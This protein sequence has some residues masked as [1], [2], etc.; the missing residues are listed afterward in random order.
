MG[1]F[2]LF[3]GLLAALYGFIRNY[4][5]AIIALTLISRIAMYPLTRKQM[6]S[7]RKMQALQPEVTR[8]RTK[9]KNNKQKMNEEM[10]ALYKESGVNPLG[11]CLPLLLQMPIFIALF[12]VL[13]APLKYMGYHLVGSTTTGH[14]VV[15]EGVSGIMRTLQQSS[16]AQGLL[17]VPDK[18][19]TFLGFLRLDC[20]ARATMPS[21]DAVQLPGN[22]SPC[23]QSWLHAVPYIVLLIAM[24]AT[25]YVQQKQMQ[26]SQDPNNPQAQQAKMMARIFPIMFLF[27]GFTFP[28]GLVIYWTTSNLWGIVQQRL[29]LRSA[30]P[31]VIPSGSGK[32]GGPPKTSGDGKA[33][34][35]GAGGKPSKSQPGKGKQGQTSTSSSS[36]GG[37]TPEKSSSRP[38]PSSKKKRKR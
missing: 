6:H 35:S 38:H 5:L 3:S 36:N 9:Y 23:P 7:M 11:G 18:V 34:K 4:G 12:S 27:F 21:F 20:S 14:W 22:A 8:V 28:V 25:T 31:T 17:D 13:R 32:K 2:E 37:K 10:M 26:A 1:F 24:T 15:N 33:L 30:P 29:V 16:L 19:N